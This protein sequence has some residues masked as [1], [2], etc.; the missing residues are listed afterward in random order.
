LIGPPLAGVLV[1]AT[2]GFGWAV[3]AAGVC[4]LAAFAALLPLPAGRAPNT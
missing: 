3:A 4:G 1:D 2:G